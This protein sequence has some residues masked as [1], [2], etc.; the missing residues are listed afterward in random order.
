MVLKSDEYIVP[1]HSSTP[2]KS[3]RPLKHVPVFP[4]QCI[5]FGEQKLWNQKFSIHHVSA[6]F[7]KIMI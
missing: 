3:A 2:Q 5:I 4:F 1:Q 7:D 6:A